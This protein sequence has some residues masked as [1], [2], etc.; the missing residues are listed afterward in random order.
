MPI[1]TKKEI[2]SAI[3]PKCW[4]C[5][6]PFA[7]HGD[8]GRTIDHYVPRSKGGGNEL[9][10][11]RYAHRYCNLLRG[12]RLGNPSNRFRAACREHNQR[13]LETVGSKVP[14]PRPDLGRKI[15]SCRDIKVTSVSLEDH[16]APL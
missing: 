15:D 4:I 6:L 10:N 5:R 11:L 14:D 1:A 3:Y 13:Q 12:S 7:V 16:Q 2:L 9:D 8:L